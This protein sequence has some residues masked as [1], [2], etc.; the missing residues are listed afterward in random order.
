MT[1]RQLVAEWV[2]TDYLAIVR[3]HGPARPDAYYTIAW[4]L[5]QWHLGKMQAASARMCL[6]V[7]ASRR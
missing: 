7:V 3:R 1:Y 6:E 2:T 4:L 5:G